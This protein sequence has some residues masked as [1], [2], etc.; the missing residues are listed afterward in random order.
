MEDLGLS[1]SMGMQYGHRYS[2]LERSI[3]TE[4]SKPIE[5]ITETDLVRNQ[6]KR[7]C[8]QQ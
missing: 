7:I 8:H 3:D 2:D 1:L 6:L 5:L 4:V